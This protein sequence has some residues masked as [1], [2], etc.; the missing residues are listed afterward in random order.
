MAYVHACLLELNGERWFSSSG[1]R[2]DTPLARDVALLPGAS[3][4]LEYQPA[5]EG[6]DE[7]VRVRELSPGG[8]TLAQQVGC[9]GRLGE[10]V[11]G[12]RVL[13]ALGEEAVR[14]ERSLLAARVELR[15]KSGD[16]AGAADDFRLLV[17]DPHG[18]AE[19]GAVRVE[20]VAES[21]RQSLGPTLL[22][23]AARFA[24][25]V[26]RARIRDAVNQFEPADWTDQQLLD[27][28]SR[29][30]P[31]ARPDTVAPLV[32][33]ARRRGLEG[34]LRFAAGLK[35]LQRAQQLRSEEQVHPILRAALRA[36]KLP[37]KPPPPYQLGGPRVKLSGREPLRLV[38]WL[39][40]AV[41]HR[42]PQGE[43]ARFARLVAGIEQALTGQT[44]TGLTESDLAADVTCTPFSVARELW[45]ARRAEGRQA[46][47]RVRSA[48]KLAART[49]ATRGGNRYRAPTTRT[50]ASVTSFLRELDE[51]LA[52]IELQSLLERHELVPR[53]SVTRILWRGA[54]QKGAL[55]LVIG[56]LSDASCGLAAR[57]KSRWQWHTG[58]PEDLLAM[59]PDHAFSVATQW[60]LEKRGPA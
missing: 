42:V 12:L 27:R 43:T 41:E 35:T 16:F 37:L 20:R 31:R 23:W 29:E 40:A 6:A 60:V 28:L 14:R 10:H 21:V 56:E 54:D 38:P 24:P 22:G 9:Y 15:L 45:G 7:I 55:A 30:G 26:V 46:A 11:H 32:A 53:F 59:V 36:V 49:L 33:E 8:G 13:A 19:S 50:G 57:T 58:P 52:L 1:R 48:A 3:V 17:R 47:A 34:D 25:P 18:Q 2:I 4:E 5:A 51:Q 44:V 39:L